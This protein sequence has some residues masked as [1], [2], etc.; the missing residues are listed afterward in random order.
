MKITDEQFI[1]IHDNSLSVKQA[2][3][4]AG[5]SESTV[6]KYRKAAAENV[7]ALEQT[8]T[9]AQRAES[10]DD[11]DDFTADVN[12]PGAIETLVASYVGTLCCHRPQGSKF[13]CG[14]RS[15]HQSRNISHC[16]GTLVPV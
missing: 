1:T 16:H 2:A 11:G 15:D 8:I 4:A 10:D 14:L 6:R 9:N 12:V 13:M 3:I 5:C 7:E